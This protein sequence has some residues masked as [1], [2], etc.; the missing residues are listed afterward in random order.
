MVYVL[1]HL[2]TFDSS[3]QFTTHATGVQYLRLVTTVFQRL[4]DLKQGAR[5]HAYIREFDSDTVH[6]KIM[7]L[8]SKRMQ[9]RVAEIC[10][11][12]IHELSIRY[13]EPQVEV[14]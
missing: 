1:L 6:A 4:N 10:D 13:T 12:M 3:A 2:K 11:T 14:L 8:I 5:E 9:D 7:R